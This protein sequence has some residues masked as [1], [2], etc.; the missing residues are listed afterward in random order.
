MSG[1]Y[2]PPPP[3]DDRWPAWACWLL[4]AT[5]SA[6]VYGVAIPTVWVLWAWYQS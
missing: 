2:T 1:I 3:E 4:Y 5:V 6:V